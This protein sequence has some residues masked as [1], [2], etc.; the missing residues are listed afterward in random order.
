MGSHAGLAT[1]AQ[2]QDHSQVQE[3]RLVGLETVDVVWG[4]NQIALDEV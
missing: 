3:L 2:G 4:R 1:E